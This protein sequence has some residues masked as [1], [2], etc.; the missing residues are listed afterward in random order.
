[1]TA[2]FFEKGFRFLKGFIALKGDVD[3][4]AEPASV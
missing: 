4:D 2:V 1:M 3:F